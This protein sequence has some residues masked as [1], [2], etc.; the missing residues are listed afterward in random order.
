MRSSSGG[1]AGGSTVSSGRGVHLDLW[2]LE[3]N[4]L[5]RAEPSVRNRERLLRG[6]VEASR[7]QHT[8]R[9]LNQGDSPAKTDWGRKEGSRQDTSLGP[10]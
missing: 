1:G 3:K 2:G 6:R 9:V 4:Q 5:S 8:P 10:G 7:K